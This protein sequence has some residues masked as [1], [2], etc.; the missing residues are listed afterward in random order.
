MKTF[1]QEDIIKTI[2]IYKKAGT[3]PRF[4]IIVGPKLSGKTHVSNKVSEIIA[5]KNVIST[6]G[7]VDTIR[8]IVGDCYKAAEDTCYVIDD[9]ESMSI[10]AKNALLKVTEE[11]P[12]RAYF[13]LN[14]T[15]ISQLP[16]TLISRACTLTLS[17][18]PEEVK[19]SYIENLKCFKDNEVNLL[20]EFCD[21]PGE[22]NYFMENEVDVAEFY[23]YIATI[24]L[25]LKNLTG[26]E[27]F[28]LNEKLKLKKES[29][30]YD[31]PLVMKKVNR[32]LL[33]A[34]EEDK[35]ELEPAFEAIACT[36][37]HLGKFNTNSA[38]QSNIFDSWV[39]ELREVWR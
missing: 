12:R 32:L 21:S 7:K 6:N 27:S 23:D 24:A 14:G 18:Y 33:K 36:T 31:L 13:I 37:A 11:P 9:F 38:S 39:L 17:M 28:R 34:M 10:N 35:I 25:K 5:G 29:E 8:A 15:N 3:I 26:V 30:G 1:G 19:K 2:E 4:I 22:V 16:Q 20:L